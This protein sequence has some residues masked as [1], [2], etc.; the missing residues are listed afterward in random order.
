MYLR[1]GNFDSQTD[2]KG[3]DSI[4]HKEFPSDN[5]CGI[6]SIVQAWHTVSSSGIQFARVHVEYPHFGGTFYSNFAP[7]LSPFWWDILSG[8]Y[9]LE[10]FFV[11]VWRLG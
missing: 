3:I 10:S 5:V 9:E 4:V 8:A 1:Q 7:M 6:D 11:A 2:F